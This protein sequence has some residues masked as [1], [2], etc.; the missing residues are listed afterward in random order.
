MRTTAGDFNLREPVLVLEV[1][2][3]S[4]SEQIE[5]LRFL[6]EKVEGVSSGGVKL[7]APQSLELNVHPDH[8][9]R[10]RDLGN[11]ILSTVATYY[12]SPA[13]AQTR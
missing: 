8:A 4:P 7:G 12:R 5:I 11:E 1:P 10:I 2:N 3:I 6:E 9:W 13:S